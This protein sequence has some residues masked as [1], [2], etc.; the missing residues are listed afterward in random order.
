MKAV[1]G[2][3]IAVV[4]LLAASIVSAR[5]WPTRPVRI[6]VGSAPG[7]IA[8]S[9]AHAIA[10]QLGPMLKQA[11]FVENKPGRWNTLAAEATA[12]STDGHTLELGIGAAHT[13]VPHLLPIGYNGN[14]DLVPVVFVGDIPNVQVV[15]HGSH[16]D[17][18]QKL[19]ELSD[20][21]TVAEAGAPDVE[22]SAWYGIYMPA[23]APKS[24]Q[25]TVHDTI[26]TV[27]KTP[28]LVARLHS[29]GA[30]ITPM[31]QLQFMAFHAARYQRYG[32]IIRKNHIRLD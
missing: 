10:D 11:V 23:S 14:R 28:A 3:T 1:I 15:S 25:D 17:S 4:L 32:N 22:I 29:I 19:I 24:V 5:D 27:L 18:L 9:V 16:I 6:L 8:D 31:T 30:E 26:S 7:G 12:K 2:T 13:I 20:V 21:P